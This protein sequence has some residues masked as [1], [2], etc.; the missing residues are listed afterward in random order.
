M[1]GTFIRNS[2]NTHLRLSGLSKVSYLH[3]ENFSIA[4]RILLLD[5]LYLHIKALLWLWIA[6]LSILHLNYI[7]KYRKTVF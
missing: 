6:F 2:V 1:A 5:F 4:A 3:A 7:I